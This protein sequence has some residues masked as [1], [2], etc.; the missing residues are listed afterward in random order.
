[1]ISLRP[2]ESWAVTDVVRV[3]EVDA[4]EGP[5][6]APDE[7]ALYFTTLPRRDPR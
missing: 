4:H 2:T 5:V 3:V 1:M 6:Y 7:D